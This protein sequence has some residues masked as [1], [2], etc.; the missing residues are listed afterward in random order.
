MYYRVL[1][2]GGQ[3]LSL[4]YFMPLR[5]QRI[6][7]RQSDAKATIDGLRAKLAPGGNVVSEAGRRKTLEVFGKPLSPSQV[8]ERICSR[9][10]TRGL[11]AVLRYTAKLDGVRLSAETLRVPAD[12]LAAAHKKAAPEF[13]ETVRRIRENI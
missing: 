7:T 13:L 11:D 2:D 5:I 10:R 6:D 12:D 9:V 3:C 1:H 4:Q 8:V